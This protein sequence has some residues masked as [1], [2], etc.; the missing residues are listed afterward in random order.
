MWMTMRTRIDPIMAL[1]HA[2]SRRMIHSSRRLLIRPSPRSPRPKDRAF[3]TD[4][5]P[6]KSHR[7]RLHLCGDIQ[8]GGDH[9][10]NSGGSPRRSTAYMAERHVILVK[11]RQCPSFSRPLQSVCLIPAFSGSGVSR[12][13]NVP[14]AMDRATNFLFKGKLVAGIRSMRS[15]L[16]L[17]ELHPS[18]CPNTRRN[19]AGFGPN[20]PSLSSFWRQSTKRK[21]FD[22]I[23][24]ILRVQNEGNRRQ[25][26]AQGLEGGDGDP[27]LRT[28][29]EECEIA[30]PLLCNYR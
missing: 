17:C 13:G 29:C 16:T 19:A 1:G 4:I 10:H 9:R 6:T 3:P 27:L 24:G 28:C 5:S 22:L 23:S 26:P 18:C 20:I 8:P 14:M 21:R 2:P 7:A 12:E 11:W 30:S 25:S 15:I